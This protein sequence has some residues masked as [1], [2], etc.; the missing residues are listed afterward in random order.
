MKAVKLVS[1]SVVILAGTACAAPW[2]NGVRVE[3]SMREYVEQRGA[4]KQSPL[5]ISSVRFDHGWLSSEAVTRIALK[6]D[7]SVHLDV[8]HQVSQI[9]GRTGWVR[10]QSVPQWP[11]ELK[12]HLDYYFGGQPPLT[13]DT[14]FA[15][16]GSHI[17]HFASPSF[18]RPLHQHPDTTVSWGGMQGTLTMDADSHWQGSASVPTL[19]LEGADGRLNVNGIQIDGKWDVHGSAIDW[20]GE[21][22]LSLAEFRY[23]APLQ[24]VALNNF[25]GA[26]SQHTKGGDI[27]I[28]YAVRLGSAS[29]SHAGQANQTF[30]NAVLELELDKLNKAALAKYSADF[31]NAQ[32][33]NMS[34]EASGRLAAQLVMQLGM[35]LLHGSPELHLKNL[36]VETPAGALAVHGSVIFDGN[37]LSE[38]PMPAELI[39]RVKAK[40]DVKLAGT[41]LRAQMQQLLRPQMEVALREQGGLNSEENLHAMTEK[42]IEQQLKGWTEAGLLRSSGQD[43][44]VDAQ[45][46]MGQVLVN[47]T[48]ANQ[49]FGGMFAPPSAPDNQPGSITPGRDDKA[50]KDSAGL[51]NQAAFASAL[52]PV[53]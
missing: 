8:R 26:F 17:S 23:S 4:D 30:S 21:T 2:Y 33:L 47:G 44:T 16:D 41:L 36:A 51:A 49:L 32:K 9:P 7:P 20:Q 40:A 6:A 1:I 38:T 28:G 19:A 31:N 10:V 43:Y 34:A 14:V 27:Q 25:T 11:A 18:V 3:H 15:Y 53:R 37:G 45:F 5:T 35:E 12:A 22:T 46:A 52:S 29:S 48:P 42:A 13:I 24:Q 39:T 50:R